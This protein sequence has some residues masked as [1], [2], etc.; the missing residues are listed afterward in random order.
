MQSEKTDWSEECKK[1]VKK[2]CYCD[3]GVITQALHFPFFRAADW[4]TAQFMPEHLRA[5]VF[6]LALSGVVFAFARR[7][8]CELIEYADFARRRNAWF[9]ITLAAF[10]AH[11]FWIYALVAGLLLINWSSRESNRVALY[12]AVLFAVPTASAQIPGL[13]LVNYL[14][15]LDHLRL[16]ALVILLPAYLNLLGKS[17]TVRFGRTAPD[18]ILLLYLLLQIILQLRETSLTDTLRQALY[19]FT[20]VFLPYFVISRSLRSLTDF[21][22]AL[23]AFVIAAMLLAAVGIFEAARHWLL[24][25]ALV[26]ALGLDWGYSAYLPRSGIIRALATAGQPIPLGYLMAV[27]IGFFLYLQGVIKNKTSSRLGLALLLGGLVAPL[28]RGPWVGVLAL[29]AVF[30][31]T[32]PSALRR[33][34]TFGVAGSLS[35][36]LLSILPGGNKIIDFLPFIGTIEKENIDYRDR[37]LDNTLVVIDRHPWFG[38]VDFAKTPE[39]QAMIQG[40]GIIDVVNTYLLTALQSGYVGMGLF[41]AFFVFAG[42]GIFSALRRLPDKES[43]AYL[44]GRA[45]LATLLAVMLIIFTVSPITII[46]VVYWSLAGM[47][48]AYTHMIRSQAQTDG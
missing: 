26:G 41:V 30:I 46:P 22:H 44:L 20:D 3:P 39:M 29:F 15:A 31:A 23:L 40:Q 36:P 18:K 43:E 11:N 19:L 27:A 48:V 34:A 8:A 7:P 33:L 6:I 45:L 9:G 16:L 42:W 10:L 13:G 5:L 28:S 38:S 32:G 12:F 4:F 37:L 47:G 17:D 25:Q 14:I 24:Y 35:L 21:R 2:N 1:G